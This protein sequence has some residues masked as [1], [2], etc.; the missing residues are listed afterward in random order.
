MPYF[1]AING[2][3][4]VQYPCEH[5]ETAGVASVDFHFPADSDYGHSAPLIRC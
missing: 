2:A 5:R 4:Y 1:S 3:L